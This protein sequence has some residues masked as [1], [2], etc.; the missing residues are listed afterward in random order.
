MKKITKLFMLLL[1][2]IISLTLFACGGSGDGDKCDEC[3]DDDN[4][5]T[6]DVC[7]EEMLEE[8]INDISLID[9]G[10]ANF[11][12]VFASD[13]SSDVR[14]VVNQKIVAKLRKDCDIEVI[15]LAE[16]SDNDAPQDVEVLIGEVTSRGEKYSFD[17]YSLGE[18]GYMIKIVGTKVLIS[19]GSDEALEEAVLEFAENIL[20][21][22]TDDVYY[23]TMT[24]DDVVYNPQDDYKIKSVTVNG[25]DMRGYTIA[26]ESSNAT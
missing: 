21:I 2:L 9:D 11:K 23:A 25:A 14:K 7:G 20:K 8:Q 19:A 6:C 22:D 15:A 16:G 24:K 18:E 3:I 1:A 13:L 4:S 10:F 17:R 5:G 26:V 12:I